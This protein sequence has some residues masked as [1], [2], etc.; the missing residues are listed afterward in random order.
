MADA[1]DCVV[2]RVSD[3]HVVTNSRIGP[4]GVVSG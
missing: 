2:V 4:K 3:C 1:W